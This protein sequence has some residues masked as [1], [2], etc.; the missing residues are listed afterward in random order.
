LFTRTFAA[1]WPNNVSERRAKVAQRHQV[2]SG[3]WHSLTTFTPVTPHT[4]LQENDEEGLV[5]S[6]CETLS[7]SAGVDFSP[8]ALLIRI[9]H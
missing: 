3:Y 6:D 4:K 8:I 1:Q 7:H 5:F 9:V 2:V